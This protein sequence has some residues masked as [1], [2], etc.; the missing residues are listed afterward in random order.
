MN[1]DLLT[2]F[3]SDENRMEN[4]AITAEE[5]EALKSLNIDIDF[6][7]E[8]EGF[9]TEGYIPTTKGKNEGTIFGNSGV[10]IGFGVDL[11]QRSLMD[12]V[13]FEDQELVKRLEPYFGL[14]KED[15]RSLLLQNIRA[16]N[17]LAI[18]ED[19]ANRLSNHILENLTGT[20]RTNFTNLF[21]VDLADVPP[22]LQ[23][24]VAS[25]GTQ[26]G[27]NFLDNPMTEEYD[28]KTPEFAKRLRRVV[29]NPE[30]VRVDP[31]GSMMSPNIEG[32][33]SLIDE[34]RNF[35]DAYDDRR[36]AEADLLQDFLDNVGRF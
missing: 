13:G 19:E 12:F 16:G 3:F 18:T 17:P 30:V 29:E 28:P 9:E 11:G 6:I 7:E 5:Y 33:E 1:G 31:Q 24:V 34:L 15:A 35:G 21:G 27:P 8:R 22:E 4:G 14:K 2:T 20:L 32:Y 10:T 36:E 23:T 25:I 26:Y